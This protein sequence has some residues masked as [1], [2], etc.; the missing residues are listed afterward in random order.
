MAVAN[1]DLK[2]VS[3]IKVESS[4]WPVPLLE[5]KEVHVSDDGESFEGTWKDTEKT[6][7]VPYTDNA[8][9]KNSILTVSV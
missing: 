3:C 1:D 6:V 9:V 2:D 5:V 7:K 4:S 8:H